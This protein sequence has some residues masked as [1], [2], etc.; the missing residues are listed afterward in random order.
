MCC[1]EH[2]AERES[3]ETWP[4]HH[5]TWKMVKTFNREN[6]AEVFEEVATGN[7]PELMKDT[8][9]QTQIT[10]KSQARQMV[11]CHG[12]T[13]WERR[14]EAA[15][16]TKRLPTKESQSLHTNKTGNIWMRWMEHA[17]I[18]VLL[19]IFPCSFARSYHDGKLGKELTGSFCIPS[20]TCVWAY[21]C[22]QIRSLI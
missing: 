22:L 3:C 19:L 17:T 6:G 8:K 1:P 7:S 15:R 10:H 14:V 2:S 21:N 18:H 4:S 9:P 12:T 13:A 20:Y 11:I 16:G 5:V